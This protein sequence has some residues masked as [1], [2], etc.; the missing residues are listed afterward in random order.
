M[1]LF[2]TANAHQVNR[3]VLIAGIITVALAIDFGLWTIAY[4]A[5]PTTEGFYSSRFHECVTEFVPEDSPVAPALFT[6]QPS[7]FTNWIMNHYCAARG[8][9]GLNTLVPVEGGLWSETI[10]KAE[11]LLQ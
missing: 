1:K 4:G 7:P 6:Y 9:L 10:Y 8:A 3:S 11:D 2:G 5:L